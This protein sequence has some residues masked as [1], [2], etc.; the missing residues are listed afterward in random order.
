MVL[1]AQ[2]LMH[3]L[4]VLVVV[5]LK[6]GQVVLARLIR[7]LLAAQVIQVVLALLAAVVRVQ[8][9]L[10]VVLVIEIHQTDLVTVVQV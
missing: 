7:V 8:L 5:L 10:L 1:V 6:R 9:V 4:V 2:L 3:K